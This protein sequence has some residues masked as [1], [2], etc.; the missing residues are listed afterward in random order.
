MLLGAH[1]SIAGGVETAPERAKKLTCDCIQIFSKNQQQWKAKPI[2]IEQAD[3]FKEN[4]TKYGVAETV[5]HDSYLINLGSPDKALLK[6]SREAFLDEMVRAQHLG[7]RYLAFHPGSHSG[8]GESEGLKKIA[9]SMNW[10]RSEFGGGTVQLLLENTAGQGSAL[11]YSF[12]HLAKIIGMQEDQK[13]VGVCF[14]TAH[15]YAA[16]YDL[17]TKQGYAKTMGM[18][19]D[20]VGLEYLKAGHLNDCK[21]AFGSRVDRHEQ[22]GKG[23]LGLEGFRNLMNDKRLARVPLNLETPAGDEK[24]KQELKLLRSLIKK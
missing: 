9:E 7:V 19:D 18:F 2:T 16:G 15:A 5:I 17:K 4:C 6:Q 24:Y 14:D 11:G 21:S 20:I 10:V 12:E 1:V 13:N 3:L 23:N 22:I 8:S